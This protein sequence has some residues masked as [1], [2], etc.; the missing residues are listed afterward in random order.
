MSESVPKPIRVYVRS[1]VARKRAY[2]LLKAVG[3]ALAIAIGW[4]IMAAALDRWLGLSSGIR[5]ALLV[6]GCAAVALIL[7]P[8]LARLLRRRIDWVGVADEIEKSNP[9]FGERLRTVISQLLERQEYRG[10]PQMLDY[11]VDQVSRQAQQHRP[12]FVSRPLALPWGV[13]LCL[14]ILAAGLWRV[15]SAD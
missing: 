2:A 8:A 1:F 11:L 15:A 9:E 14:L 7:A 6:V 10:S 13:A 5:V 4:T 12:R 3:V